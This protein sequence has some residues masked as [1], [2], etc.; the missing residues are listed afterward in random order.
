MTL[1]EIIEVLADGNFDI[2]GMGGEEKVKDGIR[3]NST[4]F[5]LLPGSNQWDLKAKYGVKKGSKKTE[6]GDN[7]SAEESQES[8]EEETLEESLG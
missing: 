4:T 7:G 8:E 1:D 2:K 5:V 6:T 3:K